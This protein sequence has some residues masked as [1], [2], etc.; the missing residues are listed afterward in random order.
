MMRSI[1]TLQ[2]A[3]RVRVKMTAVERTLMSSLISYSASYSKS[4]LMSYSMPCSMPRLVLALMLGLLSGSLAAC[5]EDQ[6]GDPGAAQVTLSEDQS[7]PDQGDPAAPDMCA[8][9]C[10]DRQCG[11]DGC[12]G[13]CGSCPTG[14]LCT[15]DGVCFRPAAPPECA[16]SCESL[17]LECGEACGVSCGECGPQSRC[18]EGRCLCQPE[19][20]GKVCGAD[21]GCG[22]VCAPCP[23]TSSCEGCAARLVI[24]EQE[25]SSE[26][27]LSAAVVALELNLNEEA[28]PEMADLRVMIEGPAQL[29]RVALG[30]PL[31]NS[32]KQLLNDPR[33]GEPFQVMAGGVHR[34]IVISTDN[35]NPI[36]NGRWIYLRLL[37]GD[38]ATEGPVQVKLLKREQTLV[39]LEADQ[40]L[41]L[42]DYERPLV[43]WP[44]VINED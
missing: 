15:E 20:T 12:G 36:T 24:H 4:R 44:E 29:A 34:F 11:D 40:Q 7:A 38:T 27:R 19:C 6:A 35:L 13:R 14:E 25:M 2:S 21:D 31:I 41:W 39:P 8:P 33:T 43:L 42:D 1:N 3:L 32:D 26:G 30:E 28:R 22:G 18:D 23:N 37:I 16:E 10:D 17:G 9:S 5:T